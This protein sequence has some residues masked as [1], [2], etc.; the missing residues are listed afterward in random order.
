MPGVVLNEKEIR[1]DFKE[2][3]ILELTN[4]EIRKKRK[5]EKKSRKIR[6]FS[7]IESAIE[8]IW[9]P[10][11]FITLSSSHLAQIKETHP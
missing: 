9:T 7:C 10:V 8:V 1:G 3:R 2:D 6:L 5:L 11:N 4:F